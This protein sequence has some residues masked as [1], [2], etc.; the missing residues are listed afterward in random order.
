MTF[1]GEII[2]A[3]K[4]EE[5]IFRFRLNLTAQFREVPVRS[6]LQTFRDLKKDF[7][8]DDCRRRRR[9]IVN[10]RIRKCS[11]NVAQ[12]QKVGDDA[13]GQIGGIGPFLLN[14]DPRLRKNVAYLLKIYFG[15]LEHRN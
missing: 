11:R 6:V 14:A 2:G 3:G 1:V 8:A 7:L 12:E 13:L 4:S 5:Q 9:E 10:D 15:K